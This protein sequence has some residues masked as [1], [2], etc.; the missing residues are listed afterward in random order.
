LP[1]EAP[2]RRTD[3]EWCR[4]YIA[5]FYKAKVFAKDEHEA[6]RVGV[7][8]Q[9][10]EFLNR[11]FQDLLKGEGIRFQVCRNPNVKR[12]V[13]ERAQRTIREKTCKYFTYKNTHRYADE[14]DRFV[15]LYNDT[16]RTATGLAPSRV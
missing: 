3:R 7:Y 10:K 8:R 13:V 9:G 16:P 6:N 15:K 12:S 2:P 4:K 14:L 11:S 1:D 5:A